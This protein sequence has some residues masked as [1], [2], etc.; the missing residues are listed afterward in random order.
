MTLTIPNDLRLLCLARAFVETACRKH[1]VDECTTHDVVV[2]VN[3][4]VSNVIR[5]AHRD[6]PESPLRLECRFFPEGLEIQV[7]DDGE[8]FDLA[9]VPDLDPAEL[10]VGGRGVFLMR[11]LMDELSCAHKDTGGNV[12]RMVKRYP[13]PPAD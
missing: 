4:A 3:E 6:R 8:P 7:T 11:A 12:L 9:A 1:G 5:H 13:S 10:R 2:A